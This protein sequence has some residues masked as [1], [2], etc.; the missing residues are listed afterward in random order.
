[1]AQSCTIQLQGT[2]YHDTNEQ[3]RQGNVG[4][5]NE[6]VGTGGLPVGRLLRLF[7]REAGR[8][9]ETEQILATALGVAEESS[10]FFF[11]NFMWFAG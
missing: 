4:T 1:M 11:S 3:G 2:F 7:V 6:R 8:L 5:A 10:L 9:G